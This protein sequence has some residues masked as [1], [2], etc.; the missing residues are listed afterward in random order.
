MFENSLWWVVALVL[1]SQLLVLPAALFVEKLP[2]KGLLKGPAALGLV[3][4]TSI[5]IL[6]WG[7]E[8]LR[9]P[10]QE[11][12]LLWTLFQPLRGHMEVFAVAIGACAGLW[13]LVHGWRIEHKT[14][15]VKGTLV[16]WLTAFFSSW[17]WLVVVSTL[18]DGSGGHNDENAMVPFSCLLFGIALNGF[19]LG[20]ERLV[21][22]IR[23]RVSPRS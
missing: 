5:A 17:A 13:R 2:R 10:D 11:L 9:G 21:W 14:P 1:L 22:R 6:T 7:D 15:W 19:V 23:Q 20:A 4:G 16:A 12:L 18:T 8:W 3:V